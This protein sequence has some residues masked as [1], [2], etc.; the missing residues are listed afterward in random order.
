MKLPDKI[1][2]V[3]DMF[4]KVPGI[5][6]KTALRNVLKITT[7]EPREL[8]AFSEALRNLA[9]IQSCKECGAYSDDEICLICS[10]EKR[11]HCGDLCVVES[12][13]DCLA[14]ERSNQ[15]HGVYHILGGVLNPLLGIGPSELKL[16]VLEKRVR[17]LGVEN[18]IL[19]ISPSV[20]GDA[21]CGYIK[22][23][24]PESVSVD[25]IGFGIPMG[26]NLD[27]LDSM[28]ISKALENK[29]KV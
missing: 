29:R 22:S 10:N 28:T 20:E 12:I 2:N 27:Y 7:W 13:T 23:I 4:S 26:G 6:E 15:F 11:K 16:D 9:E 18:L 21:T 14:I 5:G 25:R 24:L 17:E 8:M 1:L 19:A 3:V